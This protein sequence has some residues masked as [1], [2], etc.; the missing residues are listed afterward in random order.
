MI[1]NERRKLANIKKII[2]DAPI[3]ISHILGAFYPHTDGRPTKLVIRWADLC[4]RRKGG[5]PKDR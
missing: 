3:S 5:R 1:G 2:L 4:E